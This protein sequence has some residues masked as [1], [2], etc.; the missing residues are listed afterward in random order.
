M[1]LPVVS[2]SVLKRFSIYFSKVGAVSA[3]VRDSKSTLPTPQAK[4]LKKQFYQLWPIFI[5]SLCEY[6]NG[7]EFYT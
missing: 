4:F 1:F 6:R 5:N 7:F 3:P 2:P